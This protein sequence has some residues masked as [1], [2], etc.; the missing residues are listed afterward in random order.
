MPPQSFTSFQVFNDIQ[1]NQNMEDKKLQ[2]LE[3]KLEKTAEELNSHIK[4]LQENTVSEPPPPPAPIP[5]TINNQQ[6]H[7]V[8][9][10][11]L[12]TEAPT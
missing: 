8:P 12:Q 2:L 5:V 10:Q 3:E 6:S 11:E 7:L 1:E 4:K 9:D